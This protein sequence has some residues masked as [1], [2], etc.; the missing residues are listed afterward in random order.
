MTNEQLFGRLIQV[1]AL[2]LTGIAVG[3]TVG[4]TL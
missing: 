3:M 2:V 4:M 1:G